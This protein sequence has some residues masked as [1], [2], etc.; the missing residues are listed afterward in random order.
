MMKNL[1]WKII[2][3]YENSNKDWLPGE[4]GN[5]SIRIQEEDYKTYGKSEIIREALE[6]EHEKLIKIHWLILHSDIEKISYTLENM[7]LIYN[8]LGIEPKYLRIEREK[9][10]LS[11]FLLKLQKEWIINYVQDLIRALDKGRESEDLKNQSLFV[12]LEHLDHLENAMYKRIFSAQFLGGS[13]V[14]ENMLEKKIISII[15]TYKKEYVDMSDTEV[16]SQIYLE[17]Y[18]QELTLKGDLNLILNGKNLD[19]SKF[20]YGVSLNTETLMHLEIGKQQNIHKVITIENKANYVSMP[21]EKGTL[22][23]YSHGYFT[24]RE[25][26][27]LQQ[28][29]QILRTSSQSVLYYHSGDLDYGGIKIFQYTRD[30]IF[31]ELQ[32]FQMDLEQYETFLSRGYKMEPQTLEKLKTVNEPI[33]QPLIERILET[34]L[35]IEQEVFLYKEEKMTNNQ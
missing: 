17:E 27:I 31:P 4:T 28:L 25:R 35:G 14:F 10:K 24:P 33:F 15:K 8:K 11:S 18:A 16:L 26:H 12:C 30:S 29:Y 6:L 22:I 1:C 7:P 19:L 34:G 5:R 20:P 9:E 32:P 13:K 23:I 21:Y 2:T 3:K